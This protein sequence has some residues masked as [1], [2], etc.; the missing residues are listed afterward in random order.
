MHCWKETALGTFLFNNFVY[1]RLLEVFITWFI[2]FCYK[3]RWVRI[4]WFL[5]NMA[6]TVWDGANRTLFKT[7]DL[8]NYEPWRNVVRGKRTCTA[9]MCVALD[10]QKENHSDP[11]DR[12]II[13]Q[14]LQKRIFY[15]WQNRFKY[16]LTDDFAP[17]NTRQP[18]S[19]QH[20]ARDHR[21]YQKM[22]I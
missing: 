5:T 20:S 17:L 10:V 18:R 4:S 9:D 22:I 3:D 8:K 7:P 14:A 2:L 15:V 19:C 11:I 6:G 13:A 1:R 21:R 12:K 16:L